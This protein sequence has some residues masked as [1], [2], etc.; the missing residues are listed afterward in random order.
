MLY[1]FKNKNDRERKALTLK[2]V[3]FS[4]MSIIF[5]FTLF[6][7]IPFS[8]SLETALDGSLSVDLNIPSPINYS[9]VDVNNSQY[10]QGYTP[11]TLKDWIQT[12]FNS[13]YCKLTGCNITGDLKVDGTI[14]GDWNGSS[15]YVPYTGATSDV[16]LGT[17]DLTATDLTA[18]NLTV[19]T[20]T[21]F[22]DS[23]NN[24]VGIG[25]ATPEELLTLYSAS[26][27]KVLLT[28]AVNQDTGFEMFEDYLNYGKRYG[29]ALYYDGAVSNMF[30]INAYDNSLTPSTKLAI[31]R[32]GGVR[33]Y[34]SLNVNKNL[35]VG[36][37]YVEDDK[38]LTIMS[39][40]N[41]VS[42][43]NL[44][45]L[46]ESYGF[47][48]NYDGASNDF[49]I[50]RHN[51][52]T[53]GVVILTADRA[54]NNIIF[55]H[56]NQ[57]LLFGTG[58]D[59][60]ITYDG[61]NMLFNSQEVGSGDFVFNGGNVGI[62]TATPLKKLH[63][64]DTGS[65]V[66]SGTAGALLIT[67]SANARMYFEDAGGVAGNK[68]VGLSYDNERFKF[69]S[70]TD[71]AGGYVQENILVLRR[72]G[73]IGIGIDSP[74]EKLEVAGN[75]HIDDN[76]K[77]LYGTGKDASIK[78]DGTNMII[79]P[80][81]VGSGQVKINGD[82]NVTGT[83]YLII[84]Y[85]EIWF[86][87]A[88]TGVMTPTSVQNTWYNLT[89]FNQSSDS[90]QDLNGFTFVNATESLTTTTSGKYKACFS[91]SFSNAGNNQEYE[92]AIAKNNVI[93]NN[94]KIHRKI[95]AQGD[96]GNAGTCGFI[97]LNTNDLIHLQ[98][99]NV[100]ATASIYSHNV[101]LNFVKIGN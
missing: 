70:L 9:N 74:D 85:G 69:Q 58:K 17:Y 37:G 98:I 83:S 6:L 55:P 59:A 2:G 8:S 96:V 10:L 30:H 46:S 22:V 97:D 41:Y 51:G 82:L 95:G 81:E 18:T 39:G 14:Y 15:N 42:T 88:T 48:I 13:I 29:F 79:N 19:D 80:K 94:L 35:I 3:I 1:K 72:N 76:Y 21:L 50:K 38:Y 91:I 56:D 66:T 20:D 67:N 44:K 77:S 26:N 25:T 24:R 64:S 84:P 62:G 89:G 23:V 60:S 28:S 68:V 101:N 54:S 36:Q 61:T 75:I 78:Y 53:T 73:L 100:D 57:K 92:V 65:G 45:E 16:N 4:L 34:D 11:T 32:A 71:T 12:A 7:F 63:L 27:S 5:F 90:G 40:S 31:S 86:N 99:R 93:Q 33:I 49:E 47:S 87:N 52:D 43:L